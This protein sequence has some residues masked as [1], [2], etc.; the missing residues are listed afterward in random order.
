M[1]SEKQLQ[2][3][4]KLI[5][6]IV[7]LDKNKIQEVRNNVS[8]DSSTA[9]ILISIGT[10]LFIGAYSILENKKPNTESLE[11]LAYNTEGMEERQRLMKQAIS[12]LSDDLMEIQKCISDGQRE[13]TIVEHG[14]ST[15]ITRVPVLMFLKY[16]YPDVKI[17]YLNLEHNPE[18]VKKAQ[19]L[20]I[21]FEDLGIHT[22]NH[23]VNLGD[24]SKEQISKYIEDAQRG[25]GFGDITGIADVC[26]SSYVIQ[27]VGSELSKE[28]RNEVKDHVLVEMLKYSKNS[29]LRAPDDVK[30]VSEGF[31]S[32]SGN[33]ELENN[34]KKLAST[35]ISTFIAALPNASDRKY[36]SKIPALISN[37][38]G[39]VSI[40]STGAKT[41]AIQSVD[42]K[43][44]N[45]D[46]NFGWYSQAIFE[47]ISSECNNSKSPEEILN[48]AQTKCPELLKSYTICENAF[49][50]LCQLYMSN[51]DAYFDLPPDKII[52][53]TPSLLKSELKA[54]SM[55][56]KSK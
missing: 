52:C 15:L 18:A 36:A 4:T 17:S 13:F 21:L 7:S 9:D 38:G 12:V 37:N 49:Q 28:R 30:K 31:S 45:L 46:I 6:A 32:L 41:K 2:E 53:R 10:K 29:I 35:V 23:C 27:H 14:G 11:S 40:N 19:E 16:N 56:P 3:Y 24:L 51:P 43:K 54:G 22:E 8:F 33:M 47:V 1:Y 50:Q 20:S 42:V 26:L 5:E 44:N 55:A 48:E 25:A 34:L 39:E